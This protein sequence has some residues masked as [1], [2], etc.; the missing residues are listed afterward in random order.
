MEGELDRRTR[1]KKVTKYFTNQDWQ[2]RKISN[3]EIKAFYTKNCFPKM[4]D[5]GRRGIGVYYVPN[6]KNYKF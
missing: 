4:L 1:K 3:L 5:L 6:P 2:I